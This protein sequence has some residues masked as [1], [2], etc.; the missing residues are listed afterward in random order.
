[1][2]GRA[3]ALVALL[4]WALCGSSRGQV[5][6]E[7]SLP[8]PASDSAQVVPAEPVLFAH[9][10]F[11]LQLAS[12]FCAA[13]VGV[14]TGFPGPL[15]LTEDRL[16]E[17][18]PGMGFRRNGA[19][20]QAGEYH[21]FGGDGE[22]TG[23]MSDG[24]EWNVEALGFPYYGSNDPIL[25]PPLGDSLFL[26]AAPLLSARPA[27]I[28]SWREPNRPDSLQAVALHTNGPDG[29]S[30]TGGRFRGPIGG[31]Y[32]FDGQF[33]RDF[34]D[35][36]LPAAASDGHALD[37][38]LRRRISN[39]PTRLRFRQVRGERALAFRWN[40][41]TLR[42]T[43]R[44]L[45]TD[46]E[47]TAARPDEG[48]EWLLAAAL[49]H[50][51][52]KLTNPLLSARREW[53]G[54][55]L[56]AGASRLSPGSWTRNVSIRGTWRMK[57]AGLS[58]PEQKSLEL[59]VEIYRT[60]STVD[61]ALT[62]AARSESD[63]D[64][65]WRAAMAA[66]WRPAGR[67]RIVVAAGRSL[68]A[69]GLLRRLLPEAGSGN[70]SE[71]GN[72]DLPTVLHESASVSWN[73][74]GEAV[75]VVTLAA[76]GRSRDLPVWQPVGGASSSFTPTPLERRYAGLSAVVAWQPLQGLSLSGG[77][78][79]LLENNWKSG[80][81]P[82]YAPQDSWFADVR[83]RMVVPKSRAEIFPLAS[84]RGARG[85][86][87]RGDYRTYSSGLDMRIKQLLIFWR[88]ENLDDSD[89]RTGGA[90]Q[91]YDRHFAYGFR[92]EFWN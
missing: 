77:I 46:V 78:D 85:G 5:P 87:L 4:A 86:S 76:T 44:Y 61:V 71:T 37:F 38:E 31:G 49:R 7:S 59:A 48:G 51:D 68:E 23:W 6:D 52:Q 74:T 83:L 2:M 22:A 80:G 63:Q 21:W 84:V 40:A 55:T 82:A 14:N 29:F 15:G 33:Y 39:W 32:E 41:G 27:Q 3:P 34:S 72:P 69:P 50:E 54:R 28:V 62:G 56:S 9:D 20:Y 25:N 43:H 91:A 64:P 26:L 75:R 66:A 30:H 89:Y 17:R 35:G 58:L 16:A 8:L 73:F 11:L 60:F 36:H 42:A 47:A 79:H 81:E 53:F 19:P 1:M 57:D 67:H 12:R 70:F 90:A 10:L 13:S 24:S 18:L 92:W 65:L 45:L 88:I